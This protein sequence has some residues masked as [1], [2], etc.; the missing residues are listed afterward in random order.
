[1]L[2]IRELFNSNIGPNNHSNFEGVDNKIQ[3]SEGNPVNYRY[4]YSEVKG[5]NG[6]PDIEFGETSME[7]NNVKDDNRTQGNSMYSR[8]KRIVEQQNQI[9]DHQVFKKVKGMDVFYI[10]AIGTRYKLK[11]KT[12]G[13][14]QT[15]DAVNING[16]LGKNAKN[17][18]LFCCF[19][20]K[21]KNL[22]VT[23]VKRKSIW[24]IP[25]AKIVT[26][27]QFNCNYNDTIEDGRPVYVGLSGKTVCKDVEYVKV[28]PEIINKATRRND[29]FAICAK[30]VYGDF[31][32]SRLVEWFE[33]NIA[34]GVDM[35]SLFTYNVTKD[36]MKVLKHY[37]QTGLLRMQE[38]DFPLKRK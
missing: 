27:T 17:R 12:A 11:R 16:W 18:T 31:T 14:K 15:I 5:I 25:D 10:S 7:Y 26:A 23:E 38:F 19:Q 21:G 1:M 6:I 28:E 4:D 9:Y 34:A 24:E 33:Y 32:A 35:I 37:Q 36:T 30:I 29:S 22:T 13:F 3:F 8:W 20:T 2:E